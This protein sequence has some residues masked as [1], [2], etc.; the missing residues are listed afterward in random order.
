MGE[1]QDTS[2]PSL[3]IVVV[4]TNAGDRMSPLLEALSRQSIVDKL[5]VIVMGL[6]SAK[7]LKHLPQGLD[8]HFIR[9]PGCCDLGQARAEGVRHALAP[10]VAFLEDHTVPIPRWAEYVCDAFSQ[11]PGI[12][13]VS[14]VFSNGSPDTYFYRSVFIA[15]YGALAHPIPKDA[16]VGMAANNVAYRREVLTA[17]GDRLDSLIEIDFFLQ[18]AMGIGFQI[19]PA[20]RA[21]VAHQTNRR[22]IDLIRGH[23]IYAQIFALRRVQFERWSFPK[24]LAA[25][26]AIPVLV[27]WIR[28][29]RLYRSLAGGPNLTAAV[30]GLPIILALYMAGALGEAWGLIC[31]EETPVEKLV[32]L[33]LESERISE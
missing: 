1:F 30:K 23:F 14:Y 9:H 22:F 12:S 7:P 6:A 20:G 10:Y 21:L 5:E 31:H 3:T 28:I 26:A 17:F 19:L 33:E 18:K 27:P 13:A 24:R 15:E 29:R 25:M 11:S 8:V 4:T 16:A 32:W 2:R